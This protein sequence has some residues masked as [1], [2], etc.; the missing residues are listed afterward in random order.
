MRLSKQ[1]NN[2]ASVPSILILLVENAGATDRRCFIS[3]FNICN[4][5]AERSL[6]VQETFCIYVMEILLFAGSFWKVESDLTRLRSD[7]GFAFTIYL[8]RVFMTRRVNL[9]LINFIL[10]NATK[11][12]LRRSLKNNYSVCNKRKNI[13]KHKFGKKKHK[14]WNRI[15]KFVSRFL[16]KFEILHKNNNSIFFFLIRRKT[17]FPKKM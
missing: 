9:Y 8:Q 6:L 11:H 2:R 16:K 1:P 7:T 17:Y 5:S 14:N 12:P 10:A 15:G 13:S 4:V 3:A